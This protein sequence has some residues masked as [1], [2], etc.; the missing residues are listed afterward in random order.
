M[1]Q[2]H[3]SP[4]A[5][6]SY[7][8]ILRNVMDNFPLD[9][10]LKMDEKVERLLTLLEHNT[11]LCPPSRNFEGIRRCAITKYLSLAYRIIGNDIE[12]V[13]FFDNRMDLPI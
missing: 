2:I 11:H 7:A 12:L 5:K 9:I 13:V 1:H 10:A 4:D 6:D 3:W 8:A